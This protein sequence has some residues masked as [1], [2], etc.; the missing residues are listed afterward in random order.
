MVNAYQNMRRVM[1]ENP[2][3][4]DLRTAAFYLA[5]MKIAESYGTLGI[6]P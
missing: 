4:K 2:S 1:I 3:I 6:F 5:I